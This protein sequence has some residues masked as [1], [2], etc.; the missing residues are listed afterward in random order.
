[1]ILKFAFAISRSTQA[2]T[3]RG[4]FCRKII[5]IKTDSRLCLMK[6][7]WILICFVCFFFACQRRMLIVSLFTILLFQIL[8]CVGLPAVAFHLK[9]IYL[10]IYRTRIVWVTRN[11]FFSQLI[12][13]ELGKIISLQSPNVPHIFFCA[14]HNDL[15][16]LTLSFRM[17]FAESVCATYS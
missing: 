11:W 10:S 14:L 5:V 2:N 15:L 13:V 17:N 12:R 9:F 7:N 1:M 16:S 8:L 3:Q 6:K 4:N